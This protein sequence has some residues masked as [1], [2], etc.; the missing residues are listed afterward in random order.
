M[1][2]I[3]IF[4]YAFPY[5]KSEQFLYEEL[6]VLSKTFDK[7]NLFPAKFSEKSIIWDLPKNVF[8][9]HFENKDGVSSPKK[10]IPLL[11][12]AFSSEWKHG[13]YFSRYLF[14]FR[15]YVAHLSNAN[16]QSEN[17]LAFLKNSA[18]NLNSVFYTYW[19]D[20]W[21]YKLAILKEKKQIKKLVTRIHGGD[22]YEYQHAEKDFFFPFRN[23]QLSFIDKIFPISQDGLDHLKKKYPSSSLK[24]KLSRLGTKDHGVNPI[25]TKKEKFVL[26]SCSSF[27]HYK[28]VGLVPELLTQLKFPV[29]WIHI[30]EEGPEKEQVIRS[31]KFLPT[32]IK[33][34]FKGRLTQEEIF[35][36]YRTNYIDLFINVSKSEGIPVTL[37]EAI[38]FGIPIMAPNVGGIKE[39]A[40][41]KTG[42]LFELNTK[43]EDLAEKINSVYTK[44]IFIDRN[45]VRKFWEENFM[46][47]KNYTSFSEEL[48]LINA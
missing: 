46:S 10:N 16:S 4:T 44:Q 43:P 29:K 13:K 19:F 30:G 9:Y 18:I 22:V 14:G 1:Q 15:H 6:L 5:G 3:N 40:N 8:I 12:K 42:I 38:S 28:N 45:G 25:Q 27:Y 47:E 26:V 20:D 32:Y 11:L 24:L 36:F 21:T 23:F 39:I 34:E 17:L 48:K 33:P 31:S 7:I 35:D 41:N 37:M 2:E